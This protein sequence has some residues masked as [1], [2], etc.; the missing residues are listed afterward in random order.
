MAHAL[1]NGSPWTPGHDRD[2]HT[3]WIYIMMITGV[4]QV[5]T[6]VPGKGRFHLTGHYLNK[7][8]YLNPTLISLV[9]NICMWQNSEIFLYFNVS[10]I[11]SITPC[12]HVIK[13]I[14]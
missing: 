8:S 14:I 4:S 13:P 1:E 9:I 6:E 5:L 11:D 10:V 7:G 2:I 12:R 3:S